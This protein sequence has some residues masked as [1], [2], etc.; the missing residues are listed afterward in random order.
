MI[1]GKIIK[2]VA[3]LYTVCTEEG[4]FCC[5]IRGIFR[6]QKITPLIG[7]FVKISII[8]KNNGVIEQILE[9]KNV[10]TRPRVANI[11]CAI[12][13][14][15]IKS[16]DINFDLLDKFLISAEMQNIKDIVICINKCD[17]LAEDEIVDFL[18]IYQNIYNIIF[19]STVTN[20]GIDSLKKALQ[21]KVSVFAGSSGV[22]KSSIINKLLNK[23]ML[24][25]GEISKKIKRGKH[26]T[27]EVT[28]LKAEDNSYDNTYIVDTPGFTSLDLSI[29][30][31]DLAYYFKD[32]RKYLNKCKF[33]DCK[34]LKEP[35]CFIK[36]NVKEGTISNERYK[37]YVKILNEIL[38]RK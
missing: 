26:T 11:D 7:D 27:R 17:L 4:S 29:N 19:T 31:N 3:G 20:K 37:R 9:R 23:N 38:E 32:F 15:A 14:F 21:N 35:G 12:I 2:G 1:D 5:N 24:E 8:D 22:G 34:H 6:K 18:N 36:Q 30:A 16:P 10:L 13:T 33:I 28:L 25:V